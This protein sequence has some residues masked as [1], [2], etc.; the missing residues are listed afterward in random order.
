[1]SGPAADL[2][3]TSLTQAKARQLP[4]ADLFGVA[5]KL[6]AAGQLGLSA[7]LYK[8]W[9]ASNP[10]FNLLYAVHFNH[11]VVLMA[12]RDLAAAIAAFKETIRLKPDF[13]G[14]YINLGRCLED[15]GKP[16]EAIDQWLALVKNLSI[17][18]GE[19][20][21]YLITALHQ[22]GRVLESAGS[23]GP[24]EEALRQILD[25]VNAPW[26]VDVNT[27]PW[28]E[29][30]QHWVALRMK[31]CKWP[32]ISEWG[33]TS[34]KELLTDMEPLALSCLAD[35]P[36]LQL[37]KA[38][39]HG[40]RQIGMPK[41]I[42]R[43]APRS[44]GQKLR[45]GYVSSDLRGH[46]VGY[47]M[48]DVVEEHDKQS[49]E[50]FAYYCGI[51]RPDETQ[52]RIK[53]AV[54]QWTDINELNDDQ[55]AAK[56]AADGIDILVDLNGYT[57]DART[58]VFARR[59]APVAVNWFGFPATMGTPYHHYIVADSV[60]IPPADEIYYSEKVLRLPCYQPNDRKRTVAAK[61]TRAQAGLPENKF[62]YCSFNGTQKLTARVFKRWMAV[63][64]AVPDSILWLLT[65][66]E[67]TN[68]RL[69]NAAAEHG[70]QPERL[71][72]APRAN[73]ADHLARYPL[74]DVFLDSM[75][76]GA[77][78]TAADSLW[79]N[80]PV[81]TLPGRSFASRVCTTVLRA[82]GLGELVCANEQD[83]IA[84]ALE[85][86]R[87]RQK[88]AAIKAKLA[89]G[90]DASPLF[91]TPKLVRNLEDL[92]RQMWAEYKRGELPIPD[93]R[94][95]DIYHEVGCALDLE[96]VE[97]LSDEQYVALYKQKL[98][99]WHD[100]YPIARD[101]RFWREEPDVRAKRAVA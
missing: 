69:R 10:G 92:Y 19:S 41:P 84:R 47:A 52:E 18:N 78:T 87:D 34:R 3:S 46:A 29:I 90:R 35:D 24:A 12:M 15:S 75:P 66:T 16:Q 88:L 30:G 65:G 61:P 57:K 80:V 96:D 72:F 17:I 32:V 95:L 1:M 51:R 68:L 25:L 85:L 64:R 11:G 71:I 56:I 54:H 101:D 14:A 38:Y 5:A 83:F 77:H 20:L 86:G 98:A 81:V 82:A 58:K 50:I 33:R 8:T 67:D 26:S 28:A 49:F 94:N 79:M 27:I 6:E 2:Y 93:L 22:V 97:L 42:A 70:V 31:Q 21:S 91:D 45:I 7:E 59:P 53:K 44:D 74:A 100:S 4:I 62:I 23:D 48:T 36:M 40:K 89:A 60:L 43:P 39:F 9:I 37:G 63:L 73:N 99:E 76:Y 55:A 13:Q